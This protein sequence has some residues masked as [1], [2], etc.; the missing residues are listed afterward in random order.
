MGG[1]DRSRAAGGV[2][3]P[4]SQE[5][6]DLIVRARRHPLGMDFLRRGSLDSVAATFE[7]HAFVVDAARTALDGVDAPT[8]AVVLSTSSAMTGG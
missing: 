8:I 6:E 7:V 5:I 2:W 4:D 3:Q 1:M